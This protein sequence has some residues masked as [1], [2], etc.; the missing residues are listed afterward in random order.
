MRYY[1]EIDDQAVYS[2]CK[3]I[4]MPNGQWVSNPT[5]EMI[6]EAG[7]LPYIQPE[8]EEEPARE[9]DNTI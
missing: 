1:K 6:L 9:P 4:Q 3:T 8:V 2:E 7:W 5:E